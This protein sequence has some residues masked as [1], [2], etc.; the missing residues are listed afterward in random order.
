MSRLH[1]M[2]YGAGIVL[3]PDYFLPP[4]RKH[5]ARVVRPTRVE[6]GARRG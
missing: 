2:P 3:V 5:D 1:P 4:T 6:K